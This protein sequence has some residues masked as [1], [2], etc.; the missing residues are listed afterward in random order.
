MKDEISAR[1]QF[2]FKKEERLSGNKLI[3]ELF[4]NGSSFYLSPFK[5]I[6]MASQFSGEGVT[7]IRTT[8]AQV[9]ISVPKR[10]YRNAVDRNKIKRLIREAYR[11]NKHLLYNTL[12]NKGTRL[13]IAILYTSKKIEPFALIQQKL[14]EVLTRLAEK[15][16][17]NESLPA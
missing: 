17:A 10:N 13:I 2:T 5:I 14:V 1:L 4:K 8:P 9:L 11:L 16:V 12:Q 6:F 7:G 15:N 3:D